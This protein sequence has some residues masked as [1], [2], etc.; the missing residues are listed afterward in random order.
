MVGMDSIVQEIDDNCSYFI[1]NNDLR[2]KTS[3]T[4]R[5]VIDNSIDNQED[6]E[7]AGKK[8]CY[9]VGSDSSNG[10]CS[11]EMDC[12]KTITLSACQ[13]CQSLEGQIMITNKFSNLPIACNYQGVNDG[14]CLPYAPVGTCLGTDLAT[15]CL[16][17]VQYGESENLSCIPVS[18]SDV[19]NVMGEQVEQCCAVYGQNGTQNLT[20][21]LVSLLQNFENN[22]DYVTGVA[23]IDQINT[24]QCT[25][26]NSTTG[27]LSIVPDDTECRY[28]DAETLL[29]RYYPEA[30]IEEVTKQGYCKS[31][32]CVRECNGFWD[33]EFGECHSCNTT[34]DVAT[35][36]LER[37]CTLPCPNR[38]LYWDRMYEGNLTPHT[39][40]VLN[41]PEGS[42]MARTYGSSPSRF[43]YPC[44]LE[45][46]PIAVNK[47]SCETSC[48]NSG[49]PR[50]VS[51]GKC[52]PNDACTSYTGCGPQKYCNFSIRGQ[53]FDDPGAGYCVDIT[54]TEI[55]NGYS[56]QDMNWY[57]AYSFCKGLG[58]NM[59][60]GGNSESIRDCNYE[61]GNNC[62]DVPSTVPYG[63]RFWLDSNHT[64]DGGKVKWSYKRGENLA[65]T[66]HFRDNRSRAL[67]E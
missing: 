6:C 20:G 61:L 27:G 49:Y 21:E 23:L 59:V 19:M 58:L 51:D 56:E 46:A 15:L 37:Y 22:P 32:K 44:G 18:C 25:T 50:K 62:F 5:P 24:S 55:E 63:I 4:N 9:A 43:C 41:C 13:S 14:V 16:N 40:C 42:F 29:G 17:G 34:E 28:V 1:Y 53:L 36:D 12:C 2:R 64:Y 65:P 66:V 57:S 10:V 52:V 11:N 67:C 38:K 45:S 26:C 8:W 54:E 7:N 3:A 39:L 35:E 33:S 31:G 60:R 48:Q 47:A 30:S